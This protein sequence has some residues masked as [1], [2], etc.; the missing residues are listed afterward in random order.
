MAMKDPTLSPVAV[1]AI[2]CLVIGGAGGYYGR[3]MSETAPGAKNL[4]ITAAGQKGGGGARTAGPM[5]TA[6]A[7]PDSADAGA[8]AVAGPPPTPGGALARL[9]RSIGAI[10]KLQG[11]GL[12]PEQKKAM[13]PILTEIQK[14]G[15]LEG[16]AG[17]EKLIALQKT[18]SPAQREALTSL[19]PQRGGKDEGD[20][21]QP[22]ASGRN[23]Q[24]LSDLIG[25]ASK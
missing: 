8:A 10:E 23:Q 20:P 1:T 2:L 7:M 15:S 11:Q 14:A 22:F 9:V 17:T 12:S 19:N 16:S 5:G 25:V 21:A 6:M 4:D 3:Y 18:L 13:L 24:A